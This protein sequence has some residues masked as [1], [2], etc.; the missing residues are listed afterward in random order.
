[1]QKNLTKAVNG[2][3]CKPLKT[4]KV[5]KAPKKW[6]QPHSYLLYSIFYNRTIVSTLG[7]I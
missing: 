5:S 3:I 6:L 7:K 4:P 2:Y 1:M